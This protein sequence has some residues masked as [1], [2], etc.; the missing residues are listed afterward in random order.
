M[1]PPALEVS[2]F[3]E[4]LDYE[5]FKIPSPLLFIYHLLIIHFDQKL[6]MCIGNPDDARLLS[7]VSA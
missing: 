3:D 2:W 4:K 6:K 5:T 7:K 1:E